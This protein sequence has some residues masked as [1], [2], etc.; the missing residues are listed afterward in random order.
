[1]G[2]VAHIVESEG[3]LGYGGESRNYSDATAKAIDAE[4][5]EIIEVQYSRVRDLLS[6]HREAVLRVVGA[7]SSARR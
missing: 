2:H 5:R 4:V 3:Y 1:M 6:A 7:C